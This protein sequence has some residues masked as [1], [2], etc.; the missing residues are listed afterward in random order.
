MLGYACYYILSIVDRVV[1]LERWKAITLVYKRLGF[2][3]HMTRYLKLNVVI[4]R[5]C[6]EI[7]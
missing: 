2:R 7:L 4:S 1:K 3:V 6:D 5:G